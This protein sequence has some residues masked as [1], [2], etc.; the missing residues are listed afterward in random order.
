MIS[1]LFVA[2]SASAQITLVKKGKPK[3][4]IVLAEDNE[5]NRQAA[6]LLNRFVG[7]MTAHDAPQS[8][9]EAP[10][11]PPSAPEGATLL[12]RTETFVAPSGAERGAVRGA[13]RC[14][15]E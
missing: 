2:L 9:P 5:T 12:F 6:Q 11:A 1:L 7:E 10:E 13:T 15:A 14:I 4:R 8:A 3:A